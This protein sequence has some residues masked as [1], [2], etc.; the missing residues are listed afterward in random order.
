M[1]TRIPSSLKW[2]VSKRAR[3]NIKREK[4]KSQLQ[5]LSLDLKLIEAKLKS[6]DDIIRLHDIPLDLI[7]D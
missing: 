6:I 4:L 5:D 2:L 1:T 7:V 3:L